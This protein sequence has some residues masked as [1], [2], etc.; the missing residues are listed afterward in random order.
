MMSINLSLKQLQDPEIVAD[1]KQA[2]ADSGLDPADLTLEITESLMMADADLGVQRLEDLKALGVKLAM[3]DFGTGYSSLSYLSRFPV[4]VLKMDR[5]FLREGASPKASG[6]TAAVMALGKSLNLDV[7]AEGIEH[8]EQWM[9]L[10]DLGCAL[11]QGFYFARP[12]SAE[13]TM[14]FLRSHMDGRAQGFEV[15]PASV[16]AT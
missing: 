5:S 15:D 9:T 6:L 14:E 11:G 10:R 12:M 8:R 1:V 7:V 16:D 3:D 4:D 2:L 13:S